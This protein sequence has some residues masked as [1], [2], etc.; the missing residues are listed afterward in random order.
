MTEEIGEI[1]ERLKNITTIN[2]SVTKCPQK[3]YEDFV[4]FCKQ[5]TNDNYSMGL[6]DLLAS[7]K[8]SIKEVVLFQQYMELKDE[9]AVLNKK[10]EEL[11]QSRK[12]PKTFG[13]EEGLKT[14]SSNETKK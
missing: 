1:K 10:V 14:S 8:A 7:R 3:V 12:G 5:E 2:F 13:K 4:D 6:R 11:F 9:V